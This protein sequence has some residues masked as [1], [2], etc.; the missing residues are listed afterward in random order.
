MQA[1]FAETA[2][3]SPL[4]AADARTKFAVTA[5]TAGLALAASGAA[6]QGILFLATLL[7]ALNLRRPKLLVLLYAA[8]AAM[9]L[10][11]LGCA[12]ILDPFI[13]ALSGLSAKAIGIP[14]LRGASMM[15]VVVPL[16]LTSRVEDLLATLE[17]VRLPFAVFL[18]TAVMLRFIPTFANDVRQVWE[19]LRIRGWPMSPAMLL[20]H[21]ALS[22]RLLLFPI[23]FRAL[24]SSE[25]LGIAAELKGIGSAERT[26]LPSPHSLTSVDARILA[27]AA[28][29]SL[30]VV[31]AELHLSA[32]FPSAAALM[33]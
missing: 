26:I 10:L 6:A 1:L 17:R 9:M 8:L 24:K 25:S 30:F 28:L 16:A 3:K 11:A 5:L 14:F 15:N 31:L 27:A 29:A 2:S 32:L 21:P 23:L 19:T 18:P 12:L 20:L 4:A 13:P 7:Y 33:P 22:A